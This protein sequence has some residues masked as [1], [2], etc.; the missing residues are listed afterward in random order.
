MNAESV[1]S[2]DKA[3]NSSISNENPDLMGKTVAERSNKFV[4]RSSTALC[5]RWW[6]FKKQRDLLKAEK[7]KIVPVKKSPSK[8]SNFTESS[9]AQKSFQDTSINVVHSSRWQ[10]SNRIKAQR[11]WSQEDTNKFYE[12]LTTMG[13]DFDLMS[14]CFS[15]FSRNELKRKFQ[16][17]DRKNREK[18]ELALTIQTNVLKANITEERIIMARKRRGKMVRRARASAGCQE[19]ESLKKAPHSFIFHRGRVGSYVRRLIEDLRKTFSPF[20]AAKLKIRKSNSL[21]DFISIAGPLSV[22]HMLIFTRSE[23]FLNMRLIRLP[24]GPTLTFRV[25]EYT[26]AKDVV[27]A[28]RKSVHSKWQPNFAPLLIFNGFDNDIN[29]N[30]VKLTHTMFQTML[31]SLNVDSIKLNNIRRCVL[32]TYDKETEEIEFRQYAIKVVPSGV[33]KQAKV[34]L[35][36]R[37]PDLGRHQDIS[38]FFIQP[39]CLSESEQE[40]EVEGNV[41]ELPQEINAP[42]CKNATEVAVRLIEMGPRLRMQLIKIEEGISNGPVLFNRFVQTSEG[43][44]NQEIEST[45]TTVQCENT[46]TRKSISSKRRKRRI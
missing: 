32:F 3:V 16:Y 42:G 12:L 27:S 7:S 23:P 37:V 35:K 34:F 1:N 36:N 22:S 20:S 4:V 10:Y 41:V 2:N 6:K 43:E 46:K 15:G 9:A 28:L 44:T 11:R 17:E 29:N 18:V 38:D 8:N 21:K 33:S 25:L 13:T 19:P 31:P 30:N 40:G 39:Q 24:R 26:L 5:H 45:T 14:H